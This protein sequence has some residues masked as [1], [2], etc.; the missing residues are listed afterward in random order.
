[1]KTDFLMPPMAGELD[2]RATTSAPA[3][4]RP[5]PPY[6]GN[7]DSEED[8]PIPTA[9]Q[10]DKA[11]NLLREAMKLYSAGQYPE[12][13]RT[14]KKVIALDKSNVDAYYNLGAMAESQGDLQTALANYESALKIS[15][16]DNDL[17]SAVAGVRSKLQDSTF[18][19]IV[20]DQIPAAAPSY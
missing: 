18:K 8:E 5:A 6:A 1:P 9:S 12:A 11:K 13:E 14:F 7:R 3:A 16:D 15:P 19:P 4:V 17:R 2:N 20:S 10:S